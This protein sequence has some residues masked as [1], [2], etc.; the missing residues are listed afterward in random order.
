MQAC[1]RRSRGTAR[2]DLNLKRDLPLVEGESAQLSQVVMNLINGTGDPARG[3]RATGDL[4]RH[5]HGRCRDATGALRRLDALR[6]TRLFRGSRLGLRYGPRNPRSNLRPLLYNQ[7]HRARPRTCGG[8]RHRPR[9]RRWDLGREPTGARHLLSRALAGR[10]ARCGRAHGEEFRLGGPDFSRNGARD[11][12]RRGGAGTREV[13]ERAGMSVLTA[14]DGRAGVELFEKA[15]E[16]IRVILLDRTMPELSGA[17]TLEAIRKIR[18]DT[19]VV[20]VSGYSEER[21]R[22]ELGNKGRISENLA[23]EADLCRGRRQSD[24]HRSCGCPPLVGPSLDVVSALRPVR[25]ETV[26]ITRAY[27]LGEREITR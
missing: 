25:R 13:L 5:G 26:C 17:D 16:D 19:P 4:D 18:P 23:E 24:S 6:R 22:D 9:S 8:F 15:S 14:P 1:W 7:V 27:D 2:I 3:S 11:R 10:P 21:I 20:L 12:R